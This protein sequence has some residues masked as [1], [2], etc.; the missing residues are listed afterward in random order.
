MKTPF[1][2][3]VAALGLAI[4]AHADDQF[5]RV[6]HCEKNATGG[7]IHWTIDLLD[8]VGD[9]EFPVFGGELRVKNDLQQQIAQ[10]VGKFPR[11]AGVERV[12]HLVS[13]FDQVSSER[14]VRLLAIPRAPVGCAEPCLQSDERFERLAN[15]LAGSGIAAQIE[16]WHALAITAGTRALRTRMRRP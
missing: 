10:F 7:G 14:I 2:F 3:V 16:P 12:E 9:I 6:V 1:L 4:A 5:D 15:A 8:D 13:L 11:I